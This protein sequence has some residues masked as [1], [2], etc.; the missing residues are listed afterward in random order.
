MERRRLQHPPGDLPGPLG[1]LL[2]ARDAVR[3]P[4][5][6]DHGL[7][8]NCESYGNGDSGIYPGSASDI[9]DGR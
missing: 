4:G 1:D 7:Y 3:R 8:K 6:S 2:T 5:H 9:N